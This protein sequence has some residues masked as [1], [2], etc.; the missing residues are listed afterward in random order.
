[1]RSVRLLAVFC[2][3]GGLCGELLGAAPALAALEPAAEAAGHPLPGKNVGGGT[4]SPAASAAG[5]TA[6]G[7]TAAGATP[8]GA[9]PT[10]WHVA[11]KPLPGIDA[12]V[13]KRTISEAAAVAAAGDTV[14][15]HGGTY[16]ETVVI[17]ASGTAAAPI[18]FVSAPGERVVVTG[19][20]L[21][22]EWT[23]E[24]AKGSGALNDKAPDPANV[25][26]M[27]WPH[28]FMTWTKRMAHPDDDYHAVIGRAEQVFSDGYLLRQVLAKGQ[29]ARGTFFVDNEGKRLYVWT[30]DNADLAKSGTR[31]EVS[32]RQVL[33]QVKGDYVHTKGLV[34]RYAANM[35]QHAAVILE[36]RAGVLED[37][38]V[39]DTNAG[40]AVFRGEDLIVRRCV[41]QRNGQLGFAA[42]KAHRLLMTGC[43]VRENNVKGWMRGWEA[44]GNKLAL[45]R[46]VVIEKSEILENRGNGL[47][48]DI[49]NED[50][51][52]RHCRI[53]DNESAG[54]FYEISYGLH[55][56][57]N[58]ITGNGFDAE[59]GA[60]G[61]SAGIAISSSPNCR[62]ERNLLV[63][64]REG[65]AYREQHRTTARLA[66]E[67]AG[68]EPAAGAAGYPLPKKDIGGGKESPT[69]SAAGSKAA[70]SKAKRERAEEPVWNHDQAVRA[71]VLAYNRDAQVWGWFDVPDGRHWPEAIRRTLKGAEGRPPADIAADY[72][73]RDLKGQPTDL[74]LDRLRL[75]HTGNLF[76]AA[77]GQ[78]LFNWGA[79]WRHCRR[80]ESLEKVREELSLEAGSVTADPGF[81]DIA[82]R[83]FRV[84]AAS[85]ALKMGCYPQGEVP[86]VRLGA[87]TAK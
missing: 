84:P 72:A 54:I 70:G 4:G 18:T 51:T 6:A 9:K 2:A 67:P 62:I 29:L 14:V 71:N 16:R 75:T 8:T 23:R 80:Y 41:F 12:A 24:E 20:D 21:V 56:H 1:M 53:A 47:W 61:A 74:V 68:R 86:G 37:C 42:G 10:V 43:T 26:S 46:G 50:C 11:P 3:L 22:T 35:A 7:S 19:A 59:S 58:V 87:I 13:Q 48:F 40:G 45:C 31:V 77:P 60:W 63:G 15:I 38:R 57:D 33:W 79:R 73:A 83:D 32:V 81:A 39:E 36:G 34:F 78:G 76:F 82:A 25:F 28:R 27:L 44:G 55:A 66:P 5:S 30:A 64:N 69:A 17:A 85:P 65:L 49:G 52:V